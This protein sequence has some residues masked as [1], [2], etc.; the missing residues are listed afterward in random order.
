MTETEEK[1]PKPRGGKREGAGRKPKDGIGTQNI[2]LKIRKDFI[3]L[4]DENFA[5][6]SDF[7]QKAIKDKLRREGLI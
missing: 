1:T 6:R 5:N 3:A 7:I 2:S 4:I